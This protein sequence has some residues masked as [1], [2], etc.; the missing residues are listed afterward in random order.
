MFP[1]LCIR[2]DTWAGTLSWWSCQSPVAHSCSLLNHLNSFHGGMFKLKAKFDADSWLYSLSHFECDDHTIQCALISIYSPHW[3][4]QWCR[5]WPARSAVEVS[6]FQHTHT[7][8]H[9][10]YRGPVGEKGRRGHSLKRRVLLRA[11]ATPSR[12]ERAY[13][14]LDKLLLVFQA[15]Y[16]KEGPPL[17]C[18]GL[19]WVVIFADT[20]E[21]VAEYIKGGHLQ[22]K[23]RSDPNC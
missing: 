1:Q 4:V 14:C 23:G 3:V 21:G 20:G 22:C 8:T 17:L 18:K 11:S 7:H 15:P 13:P 5:S 6:V 9:T 12:G 16:I 19:L 10:D 2:C